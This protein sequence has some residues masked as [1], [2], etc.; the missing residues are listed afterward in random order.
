MSLGGGRVKPC[1][2]ELG[3]FQKLLGLGLS[4]DLIV[5]WQ[6]AKSGKLYKFIM[7]DA[8]LTI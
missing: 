5:F 1:E 6:E 8:D 4:M 3:S 2:K 7:I